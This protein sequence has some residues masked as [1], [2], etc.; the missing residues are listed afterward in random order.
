MLTEEEVI[1]VMREHLESLFPK[2]CGNCQ[3]S[4]ATLKEYLLSTTHVGSAIP[5]DA[6]AGDWRPLNPSGTVTYANCPCGNTMM[7]SSD[8]MPLP[9]LWKL[10][11]WAKKET[12]IR[13]RSPREL[14]NYLREEICKQV[15]STDASDSEN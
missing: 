9:K 5:Y 10:L 12:K 4:F 3:R 14:L 7:L 6:D 1:K 2:T 15:T 11:R 8:G 13:G